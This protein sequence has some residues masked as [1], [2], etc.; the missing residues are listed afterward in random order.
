MRADIEVFANHYR[1]KI[2]DW[3][4]RLATFSQAGEKVVVWGAGS[5][6]IM[7]LNTLQNQHQIE[8]VVDINPRKQGKYITGTGQKI[9]PPEFLQT[10]QPSLVIVM[11]SIYIQ[12]IQRT[13]REFGVSAEFVGT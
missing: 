1:Q 5:K 10:Y 11:N 6:G 13:A 7:F 9:V 8:Y 2:N 3:N 12:E 4:A